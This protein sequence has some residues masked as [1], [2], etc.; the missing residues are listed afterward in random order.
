MSNRKQA[1]RSEHDDLQEA[2]RQSATQE[3][4]ERASRRSTRAVGAASNAPP[5][6]SDEPKVDDFLP[7]LPPDVLLCFLAF[8]RPA[9]SLLGMFEV[10]TAW[11][12]ALRALDEQAVDALWCTLAKERFPIAAQDLTH[13][14]WPLPFLQFYR[15]QLR[16]E[17]AKRRGVPVVRADTDDARLA[18]RE[19][20]LEV[21]TTDHDLVYLYAYG[22]YPH[23][24]ERTGPDGF[25]D[26]EWYLNDI[27]IFTGYLGQEKVDYN[28]SYIAGY[29]APHDY[30]LICFGPFVFGDEEFGSPHDEWFHSSNVRLPLPGHPREVPSL[31][32]LPHEIKARNREFYDAELR[33]GAELRH[34]AAGSDERRAVDTLRERRWLTA[35]ELWPIKILDNCDYDHHCAIGVLERQDREGTILPNAAASEREAIRDAFRQ[36]REMPLA[37][38]RVDAQRDILSRYR[39]AGGDIQADMDAARGITCSRTDG[40]GSR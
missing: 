7:A 32:N 5:P 20:R 11:R 9:T 21:T 28:D 33:R 23:L 25:V 4:A 2:L 12:G 1:A 13:A 29:N 19:D 30:Y 10:C 38:D 24:G 37:A 16:H 14:Q 3:R 34:G 18:L 39:L 26:D 8:V 22:V 36:M 6:E 27:G 15:A 31:L 17:K 35:D 40:S